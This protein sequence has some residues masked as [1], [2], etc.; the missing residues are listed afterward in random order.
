MRSRASTQ[1]R[2]RV[3]SRY[4]T[5]STAS[6]ASGSG[7]GCRSRSARG[8]RYLDT[9]DGAK[10]GWVELGG[11]PG[12][13][14]HALRITFLEGLAG[15]KE[16]WT[17]LFLESEAVSVRV[18]RNGAPIASN[19]SERGD[20]KRFVPD[21]LETGDVVEL[22]GVSEKSPTLAQVVSSSDTRV[23]ATCPYFDDCFVTTM[24]RDA[25]E[26]RIVVVNHH[27]FFADLALRGAHPARVLPEYDAVVFDEALS[28]KGR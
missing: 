20:L 13:A 12:A 7:C 19:V 27:L 24:K 23:G 22:V 6:A 1:S 17:L 25:E 4:S 28:E 2:N 8:R 21:P 18:T 14:S 5:A 15:R 16:G 3:A 26:A 11:A 10:D 9:E